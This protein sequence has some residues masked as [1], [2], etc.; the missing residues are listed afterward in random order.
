[1]FKNLNYVFPQG[2][3]SSKV[4]NLTPGNLTPPTEIKKTETG[5]QLKVAS[6]SDL[7]CCSSSRR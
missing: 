7:T 2:S 4:K 6:H 5:K 1:M 3:R